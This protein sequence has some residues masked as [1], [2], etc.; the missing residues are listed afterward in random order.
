MP[1]KVNKPWGH[2]LIFA[3]TRKYVGKV[4]FIKGGEELSLQFHRKKDETIFIT[5]GRMELLVGDTPERLRKLDLMPGESFHIPP[6]LIHKMIAL[7]DTYVFE[8]S[9]PQLKDVV[10]LKDKY[11]RAD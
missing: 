4:L 7:T 9:T 1:F 10:R 5:K 2:E 6:N 11:G 3:K 8:V